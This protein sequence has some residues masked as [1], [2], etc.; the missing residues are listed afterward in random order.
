[1]NKEYTNFEETNSISI[2]KEPKMEKDKIKSKAKKE[3]KN[4]ILI[5]QLYK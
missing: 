5:F 4:L 3:R 2:K 1:M